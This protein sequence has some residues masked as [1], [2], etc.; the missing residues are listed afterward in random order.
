MQGFGNHIKN[1]VI[2]Y[3]QKP[4]KDFH[5]E[6]HGFLSIHVFYNLWPNRSVIP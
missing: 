3:Q 2:D 1:C 5:C 6:L 4:S